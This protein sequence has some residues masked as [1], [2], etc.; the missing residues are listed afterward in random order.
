MKKYSV[1]GI[2]VEVHS[3]LPIRED[4]FAPKFSAFEDGGSAKDN[5][6]ITHHFGGKR[7]TV[8]YPR[9]EPLYHNPPWAVYTDGSHLV[10]E[11][12]KAKPP[13]ENYYQT[14][15]ADERHTFLDIYNDE[16]KEKLYLKGG[17]TSLTMFPTDQIFLGRALAYLKG[18]LLHSVGIIYKGKGYLFVGHSDAGKTT[19]ATMFKE[20]ATILCDDRNVARQVEGEF[21]LYGTWSHGDVSLVSGTSAKLDAI[22]F[23]QQTD[24]D[25]LVPVTDEIESFERLLAC[26]IRPFATKKWWDLSLGLLNDLVDSVPCYYAK[27]TRTGNFVTTLDSFAQDRVEI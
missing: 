6:V 1:A 5:I 10:Y 11:W 12:I 27:F 16:S 7:P 8:S 2:L 9:D 3:E 14:V 15:V 23:L 17:L 22:F 19:V 21:K 25:R 24:V 4:T 13:Y 20:H 18:I 26:L